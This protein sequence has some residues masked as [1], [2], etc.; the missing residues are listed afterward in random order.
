MKLQHTP[1]VEVIVQVKP[2]KV[3]VRRLE[4]YVEENNVIYIIS[5]GTHGRF[6]VDAKRFFEMVTGKVNDENI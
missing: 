5:C 2:T 4:F 3:G 1:G 6:V